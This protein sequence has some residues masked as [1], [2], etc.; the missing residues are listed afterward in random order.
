MEPRPGAVILLGPTGS[1]K[2]PLGEMLAVRGFRGVACVH[3][4]FGENLRRLVSR[5]QPDAL[6]SAVDIK[7]LEHVLQAGA[8]L[9]DQHFPVAERILRSFLARA[10]LDPHTAVVMNGLPRHIGQARALA[11][12]LD[13][14]SVVL[15]R[16]SPQT[17]VAR[18]AAN[19]G[20]DRT[21]RTDDS[22]AAIEQ[23]L[24][25]YGQRTQ[26]L[27]EHYR[28]AGATVREVEVT[29][30]M[31]VEEMWSRLDMTP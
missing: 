15:L 6:I 24:K 26:P 19:S 28:T 27:V 25:I 18:I 22:L 13:P 4:D 10:P 16:C 2:T 29:S 9:E 12:I 7:F 5:G 8:L 1:G 23:K 3:F 14:H 31:T 11:A 21:H 17:I 20:G 30:S